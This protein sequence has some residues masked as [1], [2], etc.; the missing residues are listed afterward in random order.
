M[1][2][3][4]EWIEGDENDSRDIARNHRDVRKWNVRQ[5]LEKFNVIRGS[6]T[7]PDQTDV[8]DMITDLLHLAEELPGDKSTS[9]IIK[10]ARYHYRIEKQLCR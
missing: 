8:V 7:L 2:S 1:T 10:N 5:A 4:P 3:K 9:D 6:D